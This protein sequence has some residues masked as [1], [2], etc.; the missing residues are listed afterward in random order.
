MGLV[1]Y[2]IKNLFAKPATVIDP[3][4][5]IPVPDNYRGSVVLD[6]EKCVFCGLCQRACPAFCLEVNRK[7]G[8][9]KYN[10]S[11]CIACGRCEEVCNKNAITVINKVRGP[12]YK[13]EI[14]NY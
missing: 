12:D 13:M 8:T 10:P 7:T 2:S 9:Y 1:V 6:R 4:R 14:L 5:D 11:R 3:Y